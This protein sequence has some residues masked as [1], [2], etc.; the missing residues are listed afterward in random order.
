LRDIFEIGITETKTC[1]GPCAAELQQEVRQTFLT[2]GLPEE[3]SSIEDAIADF[4]A[5]DST[6]GQCGTCKKPRYYQQAI[7]QLPE[8]LLVQLNRLDGEGKTSSR[9][10]SLKNLVIDKKVMH[11]SADVEYELTSVVIYVRSDPSDT[12]GHYNIAAKGQVGSWAYLDDDNEITK[13][14]EKQFQAKKDNRQN[15]YV[16]A[17]RRLPISETLK[18]Q[19]PAKKT[20]ARPL[21]GNQ[22]V[23]EPVE[24]ANTVNF[25]SAEF[26]GL[27]ASILDQY[28]AQD[29]KDWEDRRKERREKRRERRN[30]WHGRMKEMR[31]KRGNLQKIHLQ[32]KTQINEEKR[33]RGRQVGIRQAKMKHNKKRTWWIGKVHEVYFV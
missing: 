13:D 9:E 1:D 3:V 7:S 11:S 22:P 20:P 10:I 30:G 8:M 16:F 19:K 27:I 5:P 33:I 21:P 4:C 32:M 15:C 31:S 25:N 18:A 12:M 14:K 2:L 23:D 17:Y 29:K 6:R 28:R 24:P 26:K